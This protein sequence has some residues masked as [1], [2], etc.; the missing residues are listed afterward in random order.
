[1]F[2]PCSLASGGRAN[3]DNGYL[4][5]KYLCKHAVAPRTILVSAPDSAAG[6]CQ[7]MP[8]SETP[9]HTKA[10]VI[11]S[12]VGSPLL[13]PGS[14]CTQRFVSALPRVCFPSPLE[15]L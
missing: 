13:S 8:L 1:M 7:P 10:S 5:Q 4:L 12:L 6:H 14:W 15:I 3:S 11:Q 9:K 2:P